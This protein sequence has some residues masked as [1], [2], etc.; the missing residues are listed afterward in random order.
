MLKRQPSQ[1][2]S[3]EYESLR[4]ATIA[5]KLFAV[6]HLPICEV[7]LS[8]SLDVTRDCESLNPKLSSCSWRLGEIS[9]P[10]HP[11]DKRTDVVFLNPSRGGPSFLKMP[12][13][14]GVRGTSRSSSQSF[15][16]HH[17]PGPRRRGPLS[18]SPALSQCRFFPPWNMALLRY[19]TW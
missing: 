19:Y 10:V 13:Q 7:L 15:T 12:L 4:A 6:K 16:G 17:R 18:L 3:R 8:L 2:H 1:S 9:P 14:G 5:C 11:N